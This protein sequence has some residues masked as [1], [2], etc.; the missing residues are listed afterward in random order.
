M[1]NFFSRPFRRTQFIAG[2]CFGALLLTAT[3]SRAAVNFWIKTNSGAWEEMQWSLGTLPNSTQAVAIV[4][5]GFKAV[6]IN[7]GTATGFPTS[8]TISNLTVGNVVPG[9]TNELLLNFFG[10]TPSLLV[11]N[12]VSVQSGGR[13]VNLFA[14]LIVSSGT[15]SISNAEMIQDGGLTLATNAQTTFDGGATYYFTNG[16][17]QAGQVQV[18]LGGDGTI[19]QYGGTISLAGMNVGPLSPVPGNGTYNLF[20]GYLTVR[21]ILNVGA[22]F[23]NGQFFQFGGTNYSSLVQVA[24]NF[25]REAIYHLNGG[26][27]FSDD[28]SVAANNQAP[29]T[30]VQFGGIHIATNG[31]GIHGSSG[32]P[33][34]GVGRYFMSAGT[35]IAGSLGL[36]GIQGYSVFAQT[37]GTTSVHGDVH[38][39]GSIEHFFGDVFLLGGTFA[40]SNVFSGGAGDNITQTGGTFIVTNLLQFEGSSSGEFV[41]Y[42][43]SAGSLTASNI[44]LDAEF[45][46]GSSAHIGRITNPGYFKMA[47]TL[48]SGDATEQFGRFILSSNSTIDLGAGNAKLSFANSSGEVWNAVF[49]FVT[50]WSGSLSGGGADQLKFGNNASGLTMSQLFQIRFLNP[51]GFEPGSYFAEILATGEVVP[52][53]RPLLAETLQGNKFVLN[54]TNTF[55]LQSSTNVGGPYEDVPGATS[56]FTN[57]TALNPREFFRLRVT[58][59]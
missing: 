5:P 14:G 24:P 43:F 7:P 35:L 55:T 13:L 3:T 44:E 23:G 37:N 12:S 30:L 31:M 2:F 6:A 38:L 11:S 9:N 19:N 48:V 28:T 15:F 58:T 57:S 50:N 27:L 32:F 16:I 36:D 26:F 22:F 42:N 49:L 52:H 53:P 17:F 20:D 8:L 4:N 10:T 54:W 1:A 25:N 18:G 21:D 47:G 29:A 46:L 39:G 56:P 40:C 33:G 51:A 45:D 34:P 41:R 59:P